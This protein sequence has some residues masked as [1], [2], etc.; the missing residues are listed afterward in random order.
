MCAPQDGEMK[1][2]FILGWGFLHFTWKLCS[3]H[4]SQ[5]KDFSC[6]QMTG[7][8]LVK[9]HPHLLHLR[10]SPCLTFVHQRPGI[11]VVCQSERAGGGGSPSS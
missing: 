1:L 2:L 7:H 3:L 8:P 6:F 4:T 9:S 11:G 5:V 10:F